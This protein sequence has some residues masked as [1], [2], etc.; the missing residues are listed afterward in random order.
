MSD[1]T[2]LVLGGTGKTGTRVTAR[3]EALGVQVR[4]GS[5][6]AAQP[7]FDWDDRDTW[8]PV[9][10]G[11]DKAYVVYAPEIAFPGAAETIA[12]FS[13][14]A[15]DA[16]VQRLVLLSGRGDEVHAG[17]SERAVRECGAE[18]TI[19][20]AA[21]FNQNFSE[22][23]MLEPVIHGVIELPASDVAEPFIDAD[24]I[25]DVAV[26]ALTTDHHLGETYELSGP[27]LLTFGDAAAEIG[28]AVGKEVRYV[29]MTFVEYAQML[30]QHGLP[31]AYV[32]MFRKVLDGRNSYLSD[33]VQR[34]LGREP[35]DFGDYARK[36]AETGIWSG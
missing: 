31:L 17:G 3:L 6:T 4:I 23:F 14:A 9:L 20:Q 10:D 2:T 33:G 18:W 34:A 35:R 16:G 12:D 36:T 11:V 5:R 21:W 26:A 30:R 8:G 32:E 19:L 25:A 1:K 29:P 28:A 7:R 24:D 27:R 13:A 15:V 22:S